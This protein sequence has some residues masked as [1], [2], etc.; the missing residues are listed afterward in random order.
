METKQ[1]A[2]NEETFLVVVN[3][4]EQYSIWPSY[5]QMPK[6]WHATGVE[7]DKKACLDHIEQVWT[8]ITP[9]SVRRQLDASRGNN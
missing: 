7:G 4:E 1:D 6:G 3:D 9:L 2:S 5:M 8:D